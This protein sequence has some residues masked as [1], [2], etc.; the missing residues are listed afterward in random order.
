MFGKFWGDH[1]NGKLM[2]LL[3][4]IGDDDPDIVIKVLPLNGKYASPQLLLSGRPSDDCFEKMKEFYRVRLFDNVGGEDD[5]K[6]LM[7]IETLQYSYE[8]EFHLGGS[9]P[10]HVTHNKWDFDGYYFITDTFDDY[11]RIAII[12]F[13]DH[14]GEL[15]GGSNISEHQALNLVKAIVK[16]L[17][18]G[19]LL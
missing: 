19:G 18:N 7:I 1:M 5:Y 8:K 12:P 2:E 14:A 4:L 13:S 15:G 11:R 3:K 17:N 6:Y 16:Q 9:V 10:K